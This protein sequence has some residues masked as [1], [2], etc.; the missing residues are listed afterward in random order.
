MAERYEDL[1]NQLSQRRQELGQRT[2]DYAKLEPGMRERFYGNDSVL[3]GLQGQEKSAIDELFSHDQSV[4]T[5]YAQN[6]QLSRTQSGRVM[7]PYA[8]ETALSNRYRG[9]AQT[10]TETRQQQQQRRDVI[11]DSIQNALKLAE[12]ALKLKQLEIEDLGSEREFAYAEL[13]DKLDRAFEREKFDYEKSKP[14]GGGGSSRGQDAT[15]E[16]LESLMEEVALAREAGDDPKQAAWK[17]INSNEPVF[18]S[19][20]IDASALWDVYNKLGG[21]VASPSKS[22]SQLLSGPLGRQG[23]PSPTNP[24]PASGLLRNLR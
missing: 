17:W 16:A 9:T 11:G 24:S 4:A 21:Q 7:D 14:K 18:R 12:Q 8:R 2:A 22:L 6:P 19:S 13:Q 1:T 10:L 20:G 15:D 3:G 5:Q 23:Q